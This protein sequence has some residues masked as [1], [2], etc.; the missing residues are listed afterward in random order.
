MA[1]ND[2]PTSIPTGVFKTG[3]GYINIATTGQKIWERF[4]QAIGA[5]EL[6]KREDYTTG[7]LQ[8]EANRKA[9]NAELNAI[10]E[11]STMPNGFSY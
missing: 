4:A 10:T 8:F 1:G 9:L 6:I 3:D 7:A 11:K 5:T 2:H